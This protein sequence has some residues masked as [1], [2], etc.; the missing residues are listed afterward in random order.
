M[1][2][3]AQ[4]R[5]AMNQLATKYDMRFI[6]A[7]TGREASRASLAN[8]TTELRLEFEAR[9]G[10]VYASLHRLDRGSIAPIRDMTERLRDPLN[11]FDAADLVKLRN[12]SIYASQEVNCD[13][14]PSAMRG[15]LKRLAQS[16][17]QTAD[18]VLRGDFGIF[19]ALTRIV[20]GRIA[21][22]RQ[23]GAPLGPDAVAILSAA[24]DARIS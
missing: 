3:T 4:A 1:N 7:P 17:E 14:S 11:G 18:D 23:R 8:S 5:V 24:R 21:A 9:E 20:I 16:L 15:V 19:E 12:P 6:A 10:L 2:L 13:P 22:E